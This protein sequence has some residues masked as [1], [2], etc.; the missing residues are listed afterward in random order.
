MPTDH[1]HRSSRNSDTLPTAS[2]SAKNYNNTNV[3]EELSG[4]PHLPPFLTAVKTHSPP[5]Q[6]PAWHPAT[7]ASMFFTPQGA[8]T[9]MGPSLSW[10]VWGGCVLG[11]TGWCPTHREVAGGTWSGHLLRLQSRSLVAGVQ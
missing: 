3:N 2:I 9:A 1:M 5:G 11:G 4:L 8:E 6:C 10:L 7:V